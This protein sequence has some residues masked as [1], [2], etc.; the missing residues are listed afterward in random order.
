MKRRTLTADRA[1]SFATPWVTVSDPNMAG[2]ALARVTP[3]TVAGDGEVFG[4]DIGFDLVAEQSADGSTWGAI[5]NSTWK[6]GNDGTE[7][8]PISEVAVSLGYVR[9]RCVLLDLNTFE[10][11]AG[12]NDPSIVFAFDVSINGG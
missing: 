9:F 12:A 8:T 6:I 7:M 4:T 5:T 11:Y 3:V 10:V 2:I 1:S